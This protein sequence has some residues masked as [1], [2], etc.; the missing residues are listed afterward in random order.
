MN[1]MLESFKY[2]QSHTH[3]QCNIFKF[4]LKKNY[5]DCECLTHGQSIM[6]NY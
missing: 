1:N 4:K 6:K 3:Q 2:L 5:K